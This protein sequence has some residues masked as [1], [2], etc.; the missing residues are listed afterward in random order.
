[1]LRALATAEDSSRGFAGHWP[2]RGG[3]RPRKRT[4]L[5]MGSDPG[6]ERVEK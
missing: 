5:G 3:D 6:W 2:E 4:A 1:M